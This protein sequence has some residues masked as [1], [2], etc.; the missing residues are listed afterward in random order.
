MSIRVMLRKDG[1]FPDT[2]I[3]NNKA[4]RE[5]GIFCARTQDEEEAGRQ[6]LY[7]RLTE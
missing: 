5:K 2:H 7:E 6:D 1:R 3:G 4:L